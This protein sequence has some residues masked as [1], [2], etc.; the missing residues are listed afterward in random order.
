MLP[1][2]LL[3]LPPP[4]LLLQSY[5]FQP[6]QVAVPPGRPAWLLL[7]LRWGRGIG[8]PVLLLEMV[9]LIDHGQCPCALQG[10]PMVGQGFPV[11]AVCLACCPLL[12]LVT[13]F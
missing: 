1:Q 5:G 4:L 2:L 12:W 3:L 11:V 13:G 10:I 6:C 8:G 9:I 7:L